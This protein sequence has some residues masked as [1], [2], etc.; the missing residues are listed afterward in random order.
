MEVWE[1]LTD[2]P[3]LNGLWSYILA[4]LNIFVPGLGTMIA[5]CVGYPDAWSKTQLSIGICQMLTSF[6]IVGWLWSV[7][8][9]WLFVAA[10]WK[11]TTEVN[12]FL[13]RTQIRS[14]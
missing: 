11:D 13:G 1:L 2:V 8:W 10:A 12:K 6:Y 3:R 4:I 14:D 7:Y 5:A 9:A